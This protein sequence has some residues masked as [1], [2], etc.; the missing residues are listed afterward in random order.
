MGMMACYM[1]ADKLLIDRLKVL[2]EEE[3]FD[4]LEELEEEQPLYDVDKMWDGLHCLMTGVS[5][6]SPINNNLLS[7]AIIGT[8][9]FFDDEYA[10]IAAWIYPDRLL[11]IV[12]ELE[13]FDLDKAIASFSPENFTKMEIYPDIWLKEDKK[14]L[15]KQLILE[16]QGLKQ[17]YHQVADRKNGIVISIY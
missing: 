8:K 17:F 7:E 3:L 11:E 1:E 6:L 13:R 14:E 16:F 4:E 5:A 12:A 2:S 15:E 10:D 9:F